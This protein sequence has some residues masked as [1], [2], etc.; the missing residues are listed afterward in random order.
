MATEC[1]RCPVCD[2]CGQRFLREPMCF[3]C[4]C[5]VSFAIEHRPD[6]RGRPM[7]PMPDEDVP[8]PAPDVR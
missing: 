1:E 4:G 5:G 7:I 8:E 6:G 2:Q 3:I